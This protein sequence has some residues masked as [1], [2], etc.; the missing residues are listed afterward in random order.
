LIITAL[1]FLNIT[2]AAMK[3]TTT[4]IY[5]FLIW[6][7]IIGSSYAQ[8]ATVNNDL[9]FGDVFPGIPK[10]VDKSTPGGAA[11]FYVTGTAGAEITIDFTLPT[12][13]NSGGWNMQ[14]VF[15]ET[16]CA[17]DSSASP[18]QTDPGADNLNPWHTITYRL[19]SAGLT[20]WL[21]GMVIPRVNQLQGDYTATIVLTVAYTGS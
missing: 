1:L 18:D 12:Y 16:D 5:F 15:H 9:T 20:I 21:G 11:E 8:N 17:V 19:G 3:Q 10:T 6:I 14:L 7:I 2:G 13:M 4:A